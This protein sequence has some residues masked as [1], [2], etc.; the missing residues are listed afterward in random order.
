MV[1]RALRACAPVGALRMFW[2]KLNATE[3]EA[4]GGDSGA[5]CHSQPTYPSVNSDS[6]QETHVS[7]SNFV[8][9]AGIVAV[10][11]KPNGHRPE[12]LSSTT[13]AIVGPNM[14]R[15][16]PHGP[17]SVTWRIPTTRH[18][19]TSFEAPHLV[20]A[21]KRLFGGLHSVRKNGAASVW[22]N[23][24]PVE[25]GNLRIK[26]PDHSD[27]FHRVPYPA[28]LPRLKPFRSCQTIYA[29]PLSPEHVVERSYQEVQIDVDKGVNWDIDHIGLV[30]Q[31]RDHHRIFVSYAHAD[32]SVALRLHKRLTES[33]L[34]AWIDVAEIQPGESLI[35]RIAAA[36]ESVDCVVALLS[37]HSIAS[38]WVQKELSIATTMEVSGRRMI[39][40]PIMLDDCRIPTSLSDKLY[41]DLRPPRKYLQ[42]SNRL[43]ALLHSRRPPDKDRL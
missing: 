30:Y 15:R 38:Q 7:G 35:E 20:I 13:T 21:C 22:L 27:W 10:A 26:P 32:K 3:L 16:V 5:G 12:F 9:A 14:A 23:G 40:V 2:A 39:V 8:S 41:I 31:V 36:L 6:W 4:L 34:K 37:K 25:R 1:S 43:E 18:S 29:W 42:C 24:K 19:P 11:A 17:S 33:G 28:N